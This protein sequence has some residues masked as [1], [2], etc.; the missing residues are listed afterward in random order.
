LSDF[1]DLALSAS[2]YGNA[3]HFR[4][5]ETSE[6]ERPRSQLFEPEERGP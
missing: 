6:A 1:R 2:P 5:T 3:S 4:A